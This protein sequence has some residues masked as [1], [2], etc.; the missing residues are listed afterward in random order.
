MVYYFYKKTAALAGRYEV[1]VKTLLIDGN[2]LINRAFYALPLLT[3]A[4]GVYTNAVYGFLKMFYRVADDYKPG[5]VVC[6]F[7]V[8]QPTFRHQR[9]AE[10][11]A[12]RKKMPEEL[13]PQIPL[14]KEVLTAL[15]VRCVEA[16][17]FE[18]DD[19]IG[20]YSLLCDGE[21]SECVI[22]T[23]DRDALQ[24][25]SENTSVW[26]T[27]KGISEMEKLTPEG[28]R[29]AYGLTPAQIC[30]LKGL[31]G[32]SSDNIPGI[33]GVGEKTALSLLEK[34]HSVEGVL[35]EAENIAGKLGE[36]IRAGREAARESK[37]LATIV[38][39]VP[40]P[41]LAD[42]AYTPP[43]DAVMAEIFA[44]Y[45]FK[46]LLE[47]TGREEPRFTFTT[48]PFEEMPPAGELLAVAFSESEITLSWGG[49]EQYSLPLAVDLLS[50]GMEKEAALALVRPLLEDE[51]IPKIFYDSKAALHECPYRIAHIAGDLMLAEYL[52]DAGSEEDFSLPH[53]AEKYHT[54]PGAAALHFIFLKQKAQL[55][56]KQLL[57]LYTDI[58][59]P[60]ARVLFL[61]E[62]TGFFVDGSVLH[63]LGA[64][65]SQRLQE[66]S[67]EIFALSGRESFNIN[68]PKQLGEVLFNDLG[69]PARR[70]TKTGFSTD[71]DVLEQLDHPIIQPIIEY[72]QAQKLKSTYVDGMF[73]LI[74]PKTGRIHS[75]FNQAV[76]ATGRISSTEP[77]LQNIPVRTAYGKNIRRA[78]C[79]EKEDFVLVNA[80]YSQIELRILAHLS[81]DETLIQAFLAGEDI[82]ART[83]AEVF[84]LDIAEV[85]PAQRSAAKAVNFGIVYGISDFG[86]AKNT[87][88]TRKE[89]ADFIE[90]YFQKY[91]KVKE[92]M[93]ACVQS[94][95]EK[96]YVVTL[97]NRRRE[98]PQ[99][100]AQNYN[101]RAFGER[102]AMNAPI[103]GTA[104][105]IIKL[106]MLRVQA[107]LE[108][109]KIDG[110]L[111]LQV[112]DELILEVHKK[113]AERAAALLKERMENVAALSVPLVA[114]ANIG[115]TWFDLK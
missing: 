68:S 30:D 12:G 51:K 23:G 65:F 21:E 36:K 87:G 3:T 20:T 90:K 10:Y 66:L 58:E 96:G 100:R 54:T 75:T 79:A 98:V 28:L 39:D 43:E 76:T 34:Y 60:L 63:A 81:G 47:R 92:Y 91:P 102:V 71:N 32:D 101:V 42:C 17:G 13:V 82:H 41:P 72:R 33:A 74:S 69:L 9:Y 15:G 50:P 78:F 40:V 108:E 35:E 4:E 22:L 88:V 14:L 94:A 85:S 57:A 106:A 5:R 38:R 59:L 48:R 80:D 105:D 8:K 103:Q 64:E 25:I 56:K 84:G 73:A 55:Q 77:N 67:A 18:A 11:K 46:S 62:Q 1:F 109:E 29:D 7:D 27:K 86:L 99:L 26:L 19:I 111:I 45:Q 61:M 114:E 6:A 89:A 110:R 44:R 93:D 113:D 83:A 52:L 49:A 24:L 16:P 53:L 107:G 104:A 70:K 95:K 115:K 97:F 31:M 112:H 37:L 2:S